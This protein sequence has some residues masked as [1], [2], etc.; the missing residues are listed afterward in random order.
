MHYP[1][2]PSDIDTS[3]HFWDSFGN[4]EHMVWALNKSTITIGN[5]TGTPIDA[6]YWF[7]AAG[8]TGVKSWKVGERHYVQPPYHN[9]G[10]FFQPGVSNTYNFTAPANQG[11]S[12]WVELTDKNGKM[13]AR[14]AVK[15]AP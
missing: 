1:V 14:S 5:T 13:F 7:R 12:F 10:P 8:Y 9:G 15:I 11:N 6:E 2:R 4:A 3:K